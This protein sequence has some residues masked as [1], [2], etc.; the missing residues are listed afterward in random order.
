M[1]T[2]LLYIANIRLPTEKAQGLQI[3]Q[4]CEAC[5]DAGTDV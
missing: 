5:A 1:K 4:K 3:R 2:K